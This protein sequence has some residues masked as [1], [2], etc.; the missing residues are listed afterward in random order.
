VIHNPLRQL[1]GQTAIYGMSSVVA[2]ILNYL[3]V[4]FYTRI[5]EP[6]EYG[7]VNELY[8]Y[9]AF[10]M[11]ILT[12]GMETAF[13]RF[14]S[15]TNDSPLVF[16]TSIITLL[17]TS[18]VCAL[19]VILFYPFIAQIIGYEG[20]REFVLLL[21]LILAIDAV[22][23][24]PFARL[25]LQNKALRFMFIKIF[26]ISA[27]IGFNLLF[28]VLF[29]WLAKNGSSFYIVDLIYHPDFGVGY[30]FLSN[31]L[32]SLFTL[33]FFLK[34]IR[35][36][37]FRFSGSLLKNMLAYSL[38]LL[39]AGF[40]G[41]VNEVIDRILLRYRLPSD[42]NAL[43]QIGIYGANVK[44]AVLM[45]LFI[46]MFRYASEPFF[47][48]QEKNI[49]SKELYARVLHYFTIF[50]V[51]VF[52]VISLY[53]DLFKHIIDSAYFEGIRVVPIILLGNLMLGI[54]YNLSVWY[55]LK[56]LTIYGALFATTGAVVTLLIN[57]VFI[58]YYGY[59]ASAW[60][61][62]ASYS[63]MVLLSWF[64]GRHYYKIPY[65]IKTILFYLSAGIGIF[66]LSSSFRIDGI[67]YRVAVNTIFI[68]IFTIIV[69]YRERKVIAEILKLKDFINKKN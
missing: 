51:F 59:M 63:A 13:F 31:F 46:Q 36:I 38:P 47:F 58:P 49:N 15:K 67:Y 1:A 16:S 44:I 54:Y 26:N 8:A 35:N 3:L 64:I 18:F 24:I 23:A 55:K 41:T 39:I 60:A 2:R 29:P 45:A 52:L 61:H 43:E 57:W 34:D 17:I 42:V 65:N 20:Q 56:E 7:V 37:N 33:F 21:G 4:P 12:Y 50:G 69:A 25:R 30:V 9:V 62:L 53:I 10:L 27:N 48:S 32:A 66:L 40:A 14:S 19:A 22:T 28:L 5:F 11:I 6:A 68:V